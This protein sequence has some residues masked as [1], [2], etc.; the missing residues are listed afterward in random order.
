MVHEP[1][2]PG[3]RVGGNGPT[4]GEFSA[5]R[6]GARAGQGL[7][8][9]TSLGTRLPGV[10]RGRSGEMVAG[11]VVS[12][13]AGEDGEARLQLAAH[14]GAISHFDPGVSLQLIR[15]ARY[16][17]EKFA[18]DVAAAQH[19]VRGEALRKTDEGEGDVTHHC[20]HRPLNAAKRLCRLRLR[21]R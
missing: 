9:D 10:D 3:L 6:A 14:Y 21:K 7:S 12:R 17:I 1:P 19:E 18:G 13:E 15:I 16:P 20:V 11:R 5:L 2:P 4:A 8:T